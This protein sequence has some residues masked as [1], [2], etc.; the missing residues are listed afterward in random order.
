MSAAECAN[1]G[2]ALPARSRFCPECG[3]RVGASDGD[4]EIQEV[5]PH[6]T[7][8]AP[9]DVMWSERRFFGVAPSTALFGLGVGAIVLGVVLLVAGHPLWALVVFGAAALAFGAFVSQTRRLPAQAS[10]V[11]RASVQALDAVK[12]RAEATIE[13][14]AAHGNSQIEQLRLRREIGQLNEEREQRLVELGAAAYADDRPATAALKE[15][16]GEL[17]GALERKRQQIAEISEAT[18]ERV[19]E[20]QL[21]VQ[22]TEI[23]AASEGAD[24]PENE[25]RPQN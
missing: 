17:D 24:T 25:Q 18:A 22:A 12:A 14:V 23:V 5:P 20:A 21:Q 9:M 11:A 1:C 3:T 15:Q 10:G 8:P 2:S 16:I 19:K 13:T 7:R 6:E 4:T